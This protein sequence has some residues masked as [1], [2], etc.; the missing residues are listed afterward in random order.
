MPFFKGRFRSK[1]GAVCGS[2][3]FG[4]ERVVHHSNSFGP[5]QEPRRVFSSSE[6]WLLG[7]VPLALGDVLAPVQERTNQAAEEFFISWSM[8]QFDEIYFYGAAFHWLFR[9]SRFDDMVSI[10]FDQI[11]FRFT[12]MVAFFMVFFK[13][14]SDFCQSNCPLTLNSYAWSRA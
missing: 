7:S 5:A 14:F 13:T 9:S 6:A 12:R 1:N 8:R 3:L 2:V 4:T 11:K 10:K